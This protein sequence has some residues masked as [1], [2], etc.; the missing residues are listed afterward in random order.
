MA[1]IGSEVDT[2]VALSRKLAIQAQARSE[3]CK[4]SPCVVVKGKG[5]GR[6][7]QRKGSVSQAPVAK[8]SL[9]SQL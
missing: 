1:S 5:K 6:I 7:L 3:E 2:T 8:A 4:G 9:I